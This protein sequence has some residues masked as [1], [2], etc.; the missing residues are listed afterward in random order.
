MSCSTAKL[1][2][3]PRAVNLFALLVEPAHRRTHAL[4]T[5]PDHVDVV[6]KARTDTL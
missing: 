6:G 5:N 1:Q 4:G 3:I 2:L